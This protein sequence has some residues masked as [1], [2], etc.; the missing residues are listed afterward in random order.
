V[1]PG[2][3]ISSRVLQHL[4]DRGLITTEQLA[5]VVDSAATS[6]VTIGVVLSE[7]GLVDADDIAEVLEDEM[8]VPHVDLASY[9][10]ED[11]ALALVPGYLA[12]EC[13][14]LPLFEIEGMLTV[15]VSDSMDVFA[16][17]RVAA[18]VG[19]EV[20][21]VMADAAALSVALEDYYGRESDAAGE[22]GGWPSVAPEPEEPSDE[23]PT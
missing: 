10:P 4:V 14:A 7:R 20:E 13:R 1:S 5:S 3:A 18:Q 6:G 11:R 9:A 19:L 23:T 22:G 8:G 2:S 17:D 12:R 16:L 21:P 15:A